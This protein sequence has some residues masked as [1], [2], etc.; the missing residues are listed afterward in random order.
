MPAPGRYA[1][2]GQVKDGSLTAGG[3][4]AFL[5]SGSQHENQLIRVVLL[6][7]GLHA[8]LASATVRVPPP[9]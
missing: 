5:V 4:T 3:K 8:G 7:T 1:G 9:S 6:T 2:D